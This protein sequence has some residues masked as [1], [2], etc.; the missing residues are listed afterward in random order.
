MNKKN[1]LKNNILKK[2]LK[3]CLFFLLIF[4]C[5]CDEKKDEN[6]ITFATTADYPPFE[7]YKNGEFVG[8]DVDLAK[9]IGKRLNLQVKFLDVPFMSILP[10]LDVG[11]ADAAIATIAVNEQR[12]KSYDFSSEYYKEKL[13]LIFFNDRNFIDL[14]SVKATKIACQIGTT[15]ELWLKSKK[16]EFE[17]D[18]QSVDNNNYAIELLKTKR[19]DAVLMD[20]VQAKEFTAQNVLLKCC[21]FGTADSGYAIAFKKCSGGADVEKKEAVEDDAKVNVEAKEAKSEGR[22]ENDG[23]KDGESHDDV[24]IKENSK[25][26]EKNNDCKNGLKNKVNAVLNDLQNEGFLEKLKQKWIK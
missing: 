2:F 24:K 23:K 6:T 18:V 22:E 15:M 13:F 20:A 7:Y 19:V 14:E 1:N 16:L 10:T 12:L 5:S 21:E 17:I 4:L 11:K 26:K 3:K 25:N 9:E 8:F